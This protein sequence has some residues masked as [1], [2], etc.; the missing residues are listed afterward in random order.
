MSTVGLLFVALCLS[1]DAGPEPA[2]RTVEELARDLKPSVVVV[3]SL[4]RDGERRGVGTG[5]V[6]HPSGLVATNLHVVGESRPIRVTLSDGKVH[7]ATAVHAFDRRLDLAVVKIDASGLPALPLAD[8]DALQQGQEV[9]ALGNPQGLEYS[10]VAGV[11]SAQREV[12]GRPMLQLAIPVEPGNSGGPVV[13]RRG[14]VCGILTMKSAVT[15]N[16]GFAVVSNALKSLLDQPKPVPMERWLTVG[17]LDPREWTALFGAQWRQRGGRLYVD[18]AGDAPG[19]GW[20]GRSLCL[21]TSAVPGVPCELSCNVKL[22]AEEGAA[23][24]VFHSDGADRCYGFYP[25]AG[26]LRLTRFDGPTVFTW[27]ILAEVRT[28]HYKPGE[29]NALKVRLEPGVVRCYVNDRLVVESTDQTY[30]GGKA[31]VAKFRDTQAEFRGFRAAA[32][33]A[34]DRTKKV[35]ELVARLAA[36]GPK[37]SPSPTLLDELAAAGP[38]GGRRLHEQAAALEEQAA[39]LRRAAVAVHERAVLNE[40][41]KLAAQ[42]DDLP[43][44]RA[45]LLIARLDNPDLDAAAYERAV[46]R[47]AE[48]V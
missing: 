4:G 20:G 41:S 11:L 22:A 24:L 36:A 38:A 10:V 48:E 37:R 1:A 19:G 31:G 8:S 33:T 12:D 34:D 28:G 9:V 45:A 39:A 35:D 2:L 46:D 16:L 27:K 30:T 6:V 40:L 17:A 23:G 14:R 32:T 26:A 18:G 15:P 5:F 43:L 29:W 21:A 44:V 42:G 13:D 47:L 25:T 3:D 7:T